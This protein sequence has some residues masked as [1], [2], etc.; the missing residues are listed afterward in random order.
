MLLAAI[1]V[2]RRRDLA[3]E[4]A[5]R[6]DGRRPLSRRSLAFDVVLALV[7]TAAE[8]AQVIGA[9]G[10]ARGS[11]VAVAWSLAARLSFVA[12]HH[13][14]CSRRRSRQPWRSWPST[15]TSGAPVLIALYTTA[16]IC[17]LRVSLA[18]LAPTVATAAVLSAVTADAEGR[19]TSAWFGAVIASALIV[20]VWALA[21]TRRL[22]GATGTSSRSERPTPSASGS[23]WRGS[24]FTRNELDCT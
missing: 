19:E 7:A 21:R 16:A 6:N 17:E 1:I 12:R 3:S 22:V 14:P 23:S 15:R 5:V 4:L 20:G 8:L 24:R 11:A 18:A 2:E 9:T 13:S 10:P